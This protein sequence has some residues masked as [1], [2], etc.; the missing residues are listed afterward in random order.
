VL[1]AAAAPLPPFTGLFLALAAL[2][3]AFAGF[4][5]ALA[6]LLLAR[7]RLLMAVRFQLGG[8]ILLPPG[9]IELARPQV[10][11]SFPASLHAVALALTPFALT[12]AARFSRGRAASSGASGFGGSGAGRRVGLMGIRFPLRRRE[13][14]NE[15]DRGE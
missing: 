13:G 5:L 10:L 8:A 12:R 6:A 7:R 4:F 2:L 3:A 1:L 9:L 11:L 14:G 15:K